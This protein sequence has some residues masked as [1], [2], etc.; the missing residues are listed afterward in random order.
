MK[1]ILLIKDM[2]CENC[3]MKID[4]V[5]S[6]TRVDYEINLEKKCVIVNGNYDM[7]SIARK[8]INEIGFTII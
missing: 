7:V 2:N 8:A 3:A 5:L 4:K 6:E 1:N